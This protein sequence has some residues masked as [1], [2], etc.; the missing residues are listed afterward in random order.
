MNL[1]FELSAFTGDNINEAFYQTT[2]LIM[3]LQN[4]SSHIVSQDNVVKFLD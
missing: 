1:F 4:K 3:E 2:K